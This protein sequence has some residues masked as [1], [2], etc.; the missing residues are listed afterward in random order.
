MTP[1]IIFAELPGATVDAA[2]ETTYDGN[3]YSYAR[4]SLQLVSRL[5]ALMAIFTISPLNL[6]FCATRNRILELCLCQVGGNI[7]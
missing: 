7:S 1:Q 2:D 4:P 5:A 6:N 3:A